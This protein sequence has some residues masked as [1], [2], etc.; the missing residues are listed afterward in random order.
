MNRLT[1]GLTPPQCACVLAM[2]MVT[3]VGAIA[4]AMAFRLW[5]ARR[6]A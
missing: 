4:L 1:L 6:T 2:F 3:L 5:N